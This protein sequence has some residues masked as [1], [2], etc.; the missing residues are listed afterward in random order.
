M[1]VPELYYTHTM[2]LNMGMAF[3]SPHGATPLVGYGFLVILT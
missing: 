3:F 1:H 2:K